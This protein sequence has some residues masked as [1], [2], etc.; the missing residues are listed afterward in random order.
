[1]EHHPIRSPAS[2]DVVPEVLRLWLRAF[3]PHVTVPTWQNLLVL[4]M[5]AL[6][7]PGKR[8]VSACLRMTG[9]AEAMKDIP[10]SKGALASPGLIAECH[11]LH[12]LLLPRHPPNALIALDPIQK[13]T[14]P[15][16]RGMVRP[17]TCP[18][19]F[20]PEVE[21]DPCTSPAKRTV[22]VKDRNDARAPDPPSRSV[23]SDLERL[24]QLSYRFAA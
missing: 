22:Q 17:S 23:S 10:G 11:V 21:H 7:A 1:M 14:G 13:K 19:A 3:R 15:F 20:R 5:G 24:S 8:T 6:L 18:R 2:G 16:A 12:R 9:R 4:V